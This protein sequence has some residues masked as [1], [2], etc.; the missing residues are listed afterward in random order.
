MGAA[1]GGAVSVV[2]ALFAAWGLTLAM[3]PAIWFVS[4]LALLA[5]LACGAIVR[6]ILGGIG[7][8]IADYID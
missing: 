6:A 5:G 2:W 7:G 1:V 3:H 8:L 4:A